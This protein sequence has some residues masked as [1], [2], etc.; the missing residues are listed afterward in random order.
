MHFLTIFFN[1]LQ[2][3]ANKL[4][5]I[6]VILLAWLQSP[7]YS[8]PLIRHSKTQRMAIQHVQSL[9]TNTD[10]QQKA[11]IGVIYK[12]DKTQRIYLLR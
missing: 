2:S 1:V 11:Q 4:L 3:M 9:K 6:M 5:Y 12:A 8:M 7:D 10:Q